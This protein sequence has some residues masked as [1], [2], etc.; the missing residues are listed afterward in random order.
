V[1]AS[2]RLRWKRYVNKLRFIHSEN[3]LVEQISTSTENEFQA[4][5][6]N[7]CIEQGID[8]KELNRDHSANVEEA[9]KGLRE[10]KTKQNLLIG[11]G[12]DQS[13]QIAELQSEESIV[14]DV[15][16]LKDASEIYEVFNKLFKKIALIL[17]PDRLGSDVS[18]ERKEE[19]LSMFNEAKESLEQ[20][21][22]FVLLDLA[23]RF[24]IAT[25]KNYEQQIRWMKKS[26]AATTGKVE[27]K[28]T[29]YNYL[30]SE[31]DTKDEKDDVV[32]KFIR[33]LFGIL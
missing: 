20:K 16:D 15:E 23:E 21:K 32:R 7:Y 26:L 29:T 30:F 31:C 27:E 18:A 2:L 13:C 1:S 3:D 33:Q 14:E 6:E 25:P 4:H 11:E 9:Y 5:L 24:S 28:K 12:E 8:L 17:H 10:E 19:Y 22:Y